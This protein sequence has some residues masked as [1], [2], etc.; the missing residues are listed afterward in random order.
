VRSDR[1]NFF[2]AAVGV[3]RQYG[4]L[5]AAGMNQQYSALPTP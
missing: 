4:A 5:P 1:F 3:D 2:D